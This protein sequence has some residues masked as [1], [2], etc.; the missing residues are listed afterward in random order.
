[1]PTASASRAPTSD[2]IVP[3]R[4]R[5][6]VACNVVQVRGPRAAPLGP[7]LLVHGAG[8]RANIFRAPVRATIVDL[9][10]D[11]GY[12]VWMENWRASIDFPPCRWTIDQAAL[13]DHPAAVETVLHETGASTLKAIVHC[14]GS[15][16]F[17]L[18][19]A[20]GLLP[21]VT[22]IV[23]NA[24]S[25]HTVVPP[26][27]R[28]KGIVSVPLLS[29]LT[30]YVDP[31]WG[32]RA[33]TAL[34]RILDLVVRATHRECDNPVCRWSSFTYGVGHPTLWRHE[35]LN[36]ATH[37]WLRR[38]FAA[39]PMSFFRQMA[40]CIAAGH[41]VGYDQPEGVPADPLAEAPRTAARFAFFAG[42]E[43][44][45][46]LPESQRRSFAWLDGLQPGFHAL[47]VIPEYGHLDVFMG[48]DAHRDVLPLMVEELGHAH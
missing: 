31:Q 18:S 35:N 5:D 47:H 44:R 13:F 28:V 29:A 8:V 39:V 15:T 41:L 14:Q 46:F 2:R 9:L 34:A 42:A 33:P 40:R 27:A 12:D 24:V 17:C 6:G 38:E 45:C 11:A 4:A 7:V 48:Q 25:F 1:M 32:V 19:A 22:A 21:Q 23:S 43:N 36:P 10:L 30:P 3:F 20:L 37:E 16:S 26:A